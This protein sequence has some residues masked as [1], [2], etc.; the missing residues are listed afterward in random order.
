MASVLYKNYIKRII[1]IVLS[2]IGLIVLSPVILVTSCLVRVKLGSPVIFKQKRPGKDEKI[3]ELYKFRTMTD[4][5]DADGN[6]LSDALRLTSFGKKLRATSL[7]ELP[8]LL[9]ILKGEMS[10]VGPRPQLVRD[11]VFM[12]NSQRKRHTVTPG[13]TGLAQ[14]KGRNNMPWE[15][16]FYWDLYY[17]KHISFRMDAAILIR[18]LGKVIRKEDISTDGMETSE[19]YGDYLLRNGLIDSESYIN[20]QKES[21]EIVEIWKKN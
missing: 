21:R 9:N 20:K 18:T 3:F 12:T 15:E 2:I 6:L 4:A 10:I 17:I 14:I 7:D 8:E 1:D 11:M 19:D 5:R 16:K 13:L